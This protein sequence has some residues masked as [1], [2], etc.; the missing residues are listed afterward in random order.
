M[1]TF[2]TLAAVAA[3]GTGIT[4]AATATVSVA[5]RQARGLL[6]KRNRRRHES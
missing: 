3:I 6:A 1:R 5:A 2:S 4:L